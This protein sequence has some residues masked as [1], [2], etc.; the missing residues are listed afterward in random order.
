MQKSLLSLILFVS[1]IQ[2]IYISSPVSGACSSVKQCLHSAV[3]NN[4]TCV[5]DCFESYNG[6]YC[7]HADCSKQ[8]V[9]CGNLKKFKIKLTKIKKKLLIN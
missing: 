1:A 2:I 9:Q 3:F 5:C 7:E 6:D 8:S 4:I